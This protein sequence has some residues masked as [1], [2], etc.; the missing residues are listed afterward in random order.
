[1]G[2]IAQVTGWGALREQGSSPN[3]LQVVEVPVVSLD[4][5]IEAYVTINN[6]TDEMMC[7]GYPQGGKDACQVMR[8]LM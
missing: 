8:I 1:M 7:A 2:E 3:Q 6:V 5:C 4:E